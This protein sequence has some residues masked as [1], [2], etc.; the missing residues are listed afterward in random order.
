MARQKKAE[1]NAEL[2]KIVEGLKTDSRF[3]TIAMFQLGGITYSRKDLIQVF[4]GVLDASAKT[5]AAYSAWLHAAKAEQSAR[6]GVRA[7]RNAFRAHIESRFGL[8]SGVLE[9]LGFAFKERRKPTIAVTLAA[10]EKRRATRA[11]R[12]TMGTKQK[13]K[14]KGAP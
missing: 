12:H 8:G 13:K 11:A 9:K 2:R 5:L 4:Q 1:H 10:V 14:M 3:N 6:L 7:T